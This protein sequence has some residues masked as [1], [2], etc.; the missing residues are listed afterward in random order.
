[1]REIKFRLYDNISKSMKYQLSNE[2][3]TLF[4]RLFE[5]LPK[6][7]HP[8]QYTGLKDKNG[9]EI[10]EGDV[11]QFS[12]KLEWYK[13]EVFKHSIRGKPVHEEIENNHIKYPYERRVIEIPECYEWMLS[14]EIQRYWEVIGNI[15]ENPELLKHK[16]DNNG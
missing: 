12:D 11:L 7:S 3:T 8:M 6:C 16:E 1:M 15:H 4:W 10:Y 13:G 5:T 2:N 14:E 9:K